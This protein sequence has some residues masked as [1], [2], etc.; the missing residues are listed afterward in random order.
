MSSK[1]FLN[2]GPEGIFS[3]TVNIEL[4]MFGSDRGFYSDKEGMTLTPNV[5]IE[6]STSC[7]SSQEGGGREGGGR[8][9]L[10]EKEMR[11]KREY[12]FTSK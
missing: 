4:R 6:G 7:F 11:E 12:I 9:V 5:R 10:T 8:Y 2:K 3:C 1:Y